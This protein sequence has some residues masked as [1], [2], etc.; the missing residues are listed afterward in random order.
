M[1][2]LPRPSNLPGILLPFGTFLAGLAPDGACTRGRTACGLAAFWGAVAT[3]ALP[4]AYLIP[5]LWLAFPALL[6][7]LQ[8]ASPMRAFL[9]GWCFGFGY[10]VLGLYWISFALL[11]DIGQFWWLLPFA[12]AGLP[13]VLALFPAL[14][15]CVFVTIPERWGLRR[16]A[17]GVIVFAVLW[18]A[19]EG[20]RGHILTGFPWH[21]IGYAWVGVPPLLQA[22][23]LFGV[24]G[25]SLVTVTAAALPYAGSVRALLAGLLGLG[26]LAGWGSWRLTQAD[27]TWVPDVRLRLVQ[28]N[29]DQRLKWAPGERDNNFARHLALSATEGSAP[30]THIIWGETA[31]PAIP[32][33][34]EAD[35]GRRLTMA[36]VT[37]EHGLILT[38]TPRVHPPADP[39]EA[40]SPR[41]YSNGL[42]A[43]DRSGAV[44][45]GFDKFH[46]V[47]F[48]EYMPLRRWLPLE[49]IAAGSIDFTP[50]PGPRTL[51]LPGLPPVSPLI[52]YEVIFP[53]AVTD[54][55]ERPAWLLN[56]TNDAWYGHSAGPH[57]HFAI[58]RA[59]AVEEGLPLVRVANTGISGVIDGHGRIVAA[60]GLGREGVVDAPL[61]HPLPS[62]PPYAR[63]GNS[64]PL[65]LAVLLLVLA[66]SRA[67]GSPPQQCRR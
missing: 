49:P 27:T 51:H 9:L 53:A 57:Q 24:Y 15:A 38:G 18:C 36:A 29:I 7:L 40:A 25:L 12:V 35:A 16:G 46:L 19:G 43:L 48:G 66:A 45:G 63:F 31:V 58:A 2:I 1:P 55:T 60:L 6:R 5:V 17:A 34:L 41:R 42:V 28:P 50:G 62:P 61:P 33:A 20:L 39:I 47:P 44:V 22:A 4:P 10:F 30:V 3:L 67:W 59:R 32:R 21:L 64:L 14:S 52:C 13:A 23:A 56:L 37:P 26:L 65:A 11:T 8:G 54:P